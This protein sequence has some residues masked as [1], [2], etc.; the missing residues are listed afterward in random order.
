MRASFVI[1]SIDE[2]AHVCMMR[3]SNVQC[4]VSIWSHAELK[5][6]I[7]MLFWIIFTNDLSISDNITKVFADE[8]A[9]W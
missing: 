2:S 3:G 7:V 9:F 4:L 1:H 8:H 5:Q 6:T